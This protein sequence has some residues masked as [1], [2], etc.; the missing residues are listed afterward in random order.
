MKTVKKLLAFVLCFIMVFQLGISVL[1][2]GESEFTPIV[3][4]VLDKEEL[5]MYYG[6]TAKLTATAVPSNASDT[7]ITWSSSNEALLHVDGEGNLTAAKDTAESPSGAQKV[8]ITATSTFDNK[9]KATCVVTVDNE[10]ESK[11]VAALK[12]IIDLIKG[13]LPTVI[14]FA[15][16]SLKPLLETIINF[17]KQIISAPPA[18]Q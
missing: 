7:G 16:T 8:T 15:K 12:K 17:F 14:E 2:S 6:T 18:E 5:T 13:A 1:G 9:V 3:G 10:P 11:I 4:I